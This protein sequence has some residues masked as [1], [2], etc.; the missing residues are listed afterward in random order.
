MEAVNSKRATLTR[1]LLRPRRWVWV[2]TKPPDG[3]STASICGDVDRV[4][5]G[6][7]REVVA[8]DTALQCLAPLEAGELRLAAELD[9]VRQGT[10]AALAG[11]LADQGGPYARMEKISES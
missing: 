9:A 3:C 10:L 5:L 7:V 2:A 11:P 8:S 1:R 4:A 6:D